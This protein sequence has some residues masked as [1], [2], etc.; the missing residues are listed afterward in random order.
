RE[1]EAVDTI[2]PSTWLRLQTSIQDASAAT[3]TRWMATAGT[4]LELDSHT[5]DWVSADLVLDDLETES[6]EPLAPGP[7]TVVALA[8]DRAG[9]NDVRAHDLYVGPRP[10]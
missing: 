1:T 10:A 9:H 6:V 8:N 4:F 7:I 5:T 3:R 2:R